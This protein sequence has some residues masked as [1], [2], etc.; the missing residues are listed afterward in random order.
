[1]NNESQGVLYSANRREFIAAGTVTAAAALLSPGGV[2]AAGDEA[3][4]VGLIGCGGRGSGAAKDCLTAD[5]GVK[6]VAVADAFDD[7]ARAQSTA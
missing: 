2:F 3:I 4:R 1:M 5:K 6:L 7:R